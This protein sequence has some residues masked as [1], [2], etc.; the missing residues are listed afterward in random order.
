MSADETAARHKELYLVYSPE[1]AVAKKRRGKEA[2]GRLAEQ[3]VFLVRVLPFPF[4]IDLYG[5]GNPNMHFE[6]LRTTMHPT[7]GKS[8]L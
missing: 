3:S 6:R 5:A 2:T 7:I 4:L 8:L 1:K